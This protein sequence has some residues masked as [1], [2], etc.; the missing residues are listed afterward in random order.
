MRVQELTPGMLLGVGGGTRTAKVRLVRTGAE[1]HASVRN[2]VVVDIVEVFGTV[3]AAIADLHGSYD[4]NGKWET[5]PEQVKHPQRRLVRTKDIYPWSD[6][7]EANAKEAIKRR[8]D[9]VRVRDEALEVAAQLG[10]DERYVNHISVA[11]PHAEFI[12]RFG[13]RAA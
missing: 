10:L 2:A 4:P 1:L 11:I 5:N 3:P 7:I 6:R 12:E 9:R 13:A 8:A